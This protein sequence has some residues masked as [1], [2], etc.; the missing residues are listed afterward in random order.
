MKNYELIKS[1]LS[2]TKQKNTIHFENA[3]ELMS[4]DDWNIF[5][6][7]QG[8]QIRRFTS[9]EHRQHFEYK[10]N[11]SLGHPKSAKVHLRSQRK[12]GITDSTCMAV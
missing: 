11:N 7:S 1:I 3:F 10:Y 9:Y 2:I 6:T 4:T 8:A 5:I 12:K